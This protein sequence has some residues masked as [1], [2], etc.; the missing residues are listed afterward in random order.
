[1]Q[2]TFKCQGCDQEKPSEPRQKGNQKYCGDRVCQ[3]ARKALWQKNKMK[4][5]VAYRTRQHDCLQRW[6]N[7]QPLD[8]YQ[9]RYRQTHPEYVK[10]NRRKQR[11]RNRKRHVETSAG[12]IVKVDA[13][14]QIKSGYLHHDETTG[15]RK[16]CR[17]GRVT[18]RTQSFK[19]L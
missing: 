7:K 17:N 6:R 12:I 18:G 4:T 16:D 15:L 14:S 1:M 5:D 19:R 11:L 3:R 13:L 2:K 8:R 10:E 9:N